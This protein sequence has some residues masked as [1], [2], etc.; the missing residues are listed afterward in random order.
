MEQQDRVSTNLKQAVISS[1]DASSAGHTVYLRAYPW[2]NA[3]S[4][5]PGHSTSPPCATSSCGRGSGSSS[6]AHTPQGATAPR[7]PP[8]PAPTPPPPPPTPRP[9]FPGYE[10]WRA[11]HTLAQRGTARSPTSRPRARLDHPPRLGRGEG[12]RRRPRRRAS[13]R[14]SRSRR[15][16]CC[17]RHRRP[18]PPRAPAAVGHLKHNASAARR[19]EI[20]HRSGGDGGEG[21]WSRRTRRS[22]PPS[23]SPTRR[24][25][26]RGGGR[27]T[28]PRAEKAALAN[29]KTK[30][31]NE[32]REAQRQAR[33]SR[34]S[35][36]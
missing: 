31:A 23:A 27:G 3:L 24:L 21:P 16:S 1:T 32:L 2:G 12:V 19:I 4:S 35:R 26:A 10:A 36:R 34:R 22:V 13:V 18:R 25:G 7:P 15:R 30:L 29:E 33:S 17:A 14:A 20:L 8:R 9:P 5:E 28:P 6:R 11:A